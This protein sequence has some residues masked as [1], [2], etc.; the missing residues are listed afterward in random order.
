MFCPSYTRVSP[1]T[2]TSSFVSVST[3]VVLIVNS[4]WSSARRHHPINRHPR[5]QPLLSRTSYAQT[6]EPPGRIAIFILGPC[7]SSSPLL[8][9]KP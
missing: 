5:S 8:S 2:S 4:L 9:G 1:R 6:L 3:I 7:P